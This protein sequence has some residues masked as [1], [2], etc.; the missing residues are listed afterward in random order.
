[1][2]NKSVENIIVHA[3]VVPGDASD[4]SIVT[5]MRTNRKDTDIAIPVSSATIKVAITTLIVVLMLSI[6]E[7]I[8]IQKRCEFRLNIEVLFGHLV[9]NLKRCRC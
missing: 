2:G 4:N 6:A 7:Q 1:M 3:L 8:G 5:S 9:N